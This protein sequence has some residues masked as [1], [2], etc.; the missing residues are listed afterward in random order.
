MTNHD[1]IS[2]IATVYNEGDNIHHLLESLCRQTC[3][4]DE[5]VIVDGGSQDDTV[6]RMTSYASRLPL[7]IVSAPGANI[8]RGRNIAIQ[9]ASGS[10]LAITDAGVRLPDDWLEH[11]AGALRAASQ[12]TVASGFFRADPHSVFEAALGATT[13]PLADEIAPETFLP[14]SRSVAVRRSAALAVGGYP[15]WLDYCEDLIF[16]LRLKATQPPFLF[17]PQACVAFRPRP[18]LPAFWR[19]YYRYARGDGKAD[20]WRKRHAIRY[21]VYVLALA[22]LGAGWWLHPAAWG[23]LAVGAAAYSATP[24]R[25]LRTVM[26]AAPRQ[27]AL[28]WAWA[29]LLIPVIRGVGDVAKMCGYPPGV[30]W[31]WRHRPPDWR[32]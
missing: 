4:P 24:A 20:L 32:L 11:L 7:R 9:H 6:A 28:A 5:V 12:A 29:L 23:L 17:V 26:R 16:D 1:T 31:R 19:Q 22:L 30:W 27:D 13:L 25:R 10:I 21:G 3:P 2:V 15:E 18:S 8:S 14:S